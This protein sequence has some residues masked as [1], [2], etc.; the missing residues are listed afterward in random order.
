MSG[1]PSLAIAPLPNQTTI[2]TI[3]AI[4]QQSSL[5]PAQCEFIVETLHSLLRDHQRLIDETHATKNHLQ[6]LYAMI[7]ETN[8]YIAAIEA[9]L[10]PSTELHA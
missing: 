5:A 2:I 3:R 9:R 8:E 1:C 4:L 6:A 10:P 7:S